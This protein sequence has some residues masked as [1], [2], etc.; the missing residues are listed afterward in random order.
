MGFVGTWVGQALI[1][2]IGLLRTGVCA[3]LHS[4][5]GQPAS[6]TNLPTKAS[7]TIRIQSM[8]FES[9]HRAYTT[10]VMVQVTFGSSPHTS[11][12]GHSCISLGAGYCRG[13]PV[14]LV[15]LWHDCLV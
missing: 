13:A 5:T 14:H 12:R 11:G 15:L 6:F 7:G 8:Q 3:L 1:G 10:S 4:F 2:S 9:R